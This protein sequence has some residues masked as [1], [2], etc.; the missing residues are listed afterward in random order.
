MTLPSVQNLGLSIHSYDALKGVTF[1]IGEGEIVTFTSESGSGKSMTALATMQ[2]LPRGANPQGHIMLGARD[3]LT[4]REAELCAIRGNDISMVF[5]EPMT[6]L[7]SAKAIGDQVTRALIIRPDLTVFNEAVSALDVS[8][9][10]QILD[11]LVELCR[12]YSLSYLFISHG[13]SVVRNITDR[14]LVMKQGKIVE[15]GATEAVFTNPRHLYTKSL[16]DA[17][18]VPPDLKGLSA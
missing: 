7:N 2:L 14:V 16:I 11:L 15:Q 18:P 4:L 12:A 13:L 3:L 9:R 8:V 5:Q 1:Y 6:V 10:A 17:A